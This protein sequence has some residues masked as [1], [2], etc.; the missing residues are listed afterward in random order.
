M[1]RMA[2]PF[3]MGCMKPDRGKSGP[4][5]PA[6]QFL[7]CICSADKIP[8]RLIFRPFELKK[9]PRPAMLNGTCPGQIGHRGREILA[10]L[11]RPIGAES[12][13]PRPA[14]LRAFSGIAIRPAMRQSIR[15]GSLPA[16]GGR[17]VLDRAD[18]GTSDRRGRAGEK[19]HADKGMPRP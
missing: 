8:A 17:T 5:P 9:S 10:P 19:M 11:P 4:F 16:T 2:H 18:R 1:S 3:G 7:E 15:S 14:V 6:F 12:R 13:G